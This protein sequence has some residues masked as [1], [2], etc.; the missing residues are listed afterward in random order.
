MFTLFRKFDL[1]TIDSRIKSNVI[2]FLSIILYVSVFLIRISKYEWNP[3]ALTGFGC[4]SPDV[5]FA[6]QNRKI[7]PEDAVVFR[8]GGY[9]GQFYYYIAASIFSGERPG[10]DSYPFRMARIGYP[11]IASP[12][13]FFGPGFLN[14][15]MTALL[16]FFH[17][18]GYLFLYRFLEVQKTD[19][20]RSRSIFYLA[21]SS[22][23]L[24]PYSLLGFMLHLSEG[25]ALSFSI[26][27]IYFYFKARNVGASVNYLFSF[28][29][30]S[31]SLLTKEIFLVV[32]AG[33]AA[34]AVFDLMKGNRREGFYKLLFWL[35]A[36][37]P[38]FLWWYR[39]GFSPFAAAGHGDI[40]FFGIYEYLRNPDSMLS[41]RG[42]LTMILFFYII[43]LFV[44]IK[45]MAMNF[46]QSSELEIAAVFIM[47]ANIFLISL[48]S[49]QEYWMNFA[50]I[51]RFF[52][53]LVLSLILVAKTF[54]LKESVD[55]S[56]SVKILFFL[57]IFLSAELIRREVGSAPLFYDIF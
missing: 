32:P 52:S 50:N 29:F 44:R 2:L 1:E 48:A 11:L 27:A 5:C 6:E 12:G 9:D 22:Y 10:L 54:R 31:Y 53:P 28:L 19:S 36:C 38:L 56:F 18:I 46:R 49:G 34:A 45:V 24:N 42:I 47:F 37:L 7:L 14:L 35:S 15:F 55:F 4:F 13:Y 43:A 8:S 25:V 57:N 23:A 41:P 17:V 21:L 26:A 20:A 40:P 51:G 33:F 16:L 39:I 3:T 30:V